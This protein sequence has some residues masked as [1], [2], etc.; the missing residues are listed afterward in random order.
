MVRPGLP[1]PK[2]EKSS[3]GSLSGKEVLK[4]FE[5]DTSDISILKRG[6]SQ[7]QE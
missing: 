7:K 3:M 2:T 6:N 4:N 5:F 1:T